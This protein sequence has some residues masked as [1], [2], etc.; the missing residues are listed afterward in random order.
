MDYFNKYY[1]GVLKKYAGFN[2]RARR[3]EYWYFLLFDF[4]I[5]MGLV[6]IEGLLGITPHTDE[7]VLFW[8][9]NLAVLIPSIAVG[10][11]RMHDVN[12]SGWFLLVPI[13]SFILT[14][15]EGTKGDNRYGLDPKI[16]NNEDKLHIHPT[17]MSMPT[18]K[19][20][21]NY[22][23]NCG[24][25]IEENAFFCTYCGN[26]LSGINNPKKNAKRIGWY[27]DSIDHFLCNDCF[28]VI[29]G[30]TEEDYKPILDSDVKQD[31][32][33]CDACKKNF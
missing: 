16:V 13:Y 18:E 9:Y 19:I 22:C 23:P 17:N 21:L 28:K 5:A 29:K 14:I 7:S 11:R 6:F 25:R 30:I 1:L 8:V 4:I 10:V 20:G 31:T 3:A 12:K 24:K 27:K 2:G 15:T 33:T 26:K 32:Y